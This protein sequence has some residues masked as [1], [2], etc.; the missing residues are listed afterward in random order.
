MEQ[1]FGVAF[2]PGATNLQALDEAVAREMPTPVGRRKTFGFSLT[3]SVC[4]GKGHSLCPG[5]LQSN[6]FFRNRVYRNSLSL[7]GEG[8]SQSTFLAEDSRAYTIATAVTSNSSS[9]TSRSIGP[10]RRM[11]CIDTPVADGKLLPKNFR[12]TSPTRR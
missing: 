7:K 10:G 11:R 9:G 12:R 6:L 8:I 2:G 4:S 5:R 1:G 3:K